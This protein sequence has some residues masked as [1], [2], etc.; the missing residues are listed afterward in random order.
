MFLISVCFRP[1]RSRENDNKA[2]IAFSVLPDTDRMSRELSVASI[3]TSR[4]PTMAFCRLK[5][6]RQSHRFACYT[7]L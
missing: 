3:L 4:G 1:L 7:A 6:N 5:E 2:G